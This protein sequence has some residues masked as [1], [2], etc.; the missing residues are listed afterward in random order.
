MII[1][2]IIAQTISANQDKKEII[3][4]FALLFVA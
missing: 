3:E 4:A 2:Q 1:N